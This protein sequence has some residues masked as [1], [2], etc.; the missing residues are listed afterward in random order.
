MSPCKAFANTARPI[1][2]ARMRQKR[3]I[4]ETV[5]IRNWPTRACRHRRKS[6]GS[7]QR[8]KAFELMR[9]VLFTRFLFSII[10]VAT[11]GVAVAAS[12]DPDKDPK[13]VALLGEARHLID[14]R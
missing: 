5:I 9:A 8:W 10:A 6:A 14:S 1:R 2:I 7:L 13:M 11:V 4:S 12:D 3:S